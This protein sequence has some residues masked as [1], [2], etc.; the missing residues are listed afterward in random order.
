[1]ATLS[2]AG[3]IRWKMAKSVS[4]L[5]SEAGGY[6]F[7]GFIRDS[8][9]HDEAAKSF[10]SSVHNIDNSGDDIYHLYNDKN[11]LPEFN[12]RLLQIN[13]IDCYMTTKELPNIEKILEK[14]QY[15]IE[16]KREK[17]VKFYFANGEEIQSDLKL[18]KAIVKFK[19][20][21]VLQS[22]VNKYDYY[23]KLDI[24]HGHTTSF[25]I[26]KTI[27]AN[28]DFECNSLILTPENNYIIAGS[29]FKSLDPI[30]KLKKIEYIISFIKEKKAVLFNK[31]NKF[32]VY[33]SRVEKML[34]KGFS[35]ITR[36]T[37]NIKNDG[38]QTCIICMNDISVKLIHTKHIH[39]SARFCVKCFIKL[40]THENYKN[41]C[42]L[43]KRDCFVFGREL[44][45]YKA[46][47]CFRSFEYN[48]DSDE[49]S[50]DILVI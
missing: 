38:E 22:V 24:I 12:D 48:D 37:I 20:N 2:N 27:S 4:R 21:E 15:Y 16:F 17:P 13:D 29:D 26:Y 40:I 14:N 33:E 50:N 43:C 3:M 32:G 6:I 35:I 44:D 46:I 11:I 10:Y 34:K 9:I 19:T 25:E 18:T 36:N 28:M 7:G 47:T 8:I 5:I 42:P 23:I 41:D 30:E 31:T 49:E 39:C 45:L 1:M